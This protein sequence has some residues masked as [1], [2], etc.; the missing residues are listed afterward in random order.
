MPFTDVMANEVAVVSEEPTPGY[1]T[2]SIVCTSDIADSPNTNRSRTADSLELTPV[3]GENIS[4]V[5]TN[6]DV[7]PT[8]TITKVVVGSRGRRERSRCCSAASTR[9]KASRSP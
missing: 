8:V 7:A 9:R 4:C 5:I 3:L 2:A 6:D 1:T